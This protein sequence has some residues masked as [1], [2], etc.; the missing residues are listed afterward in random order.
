MSESDVVDVI[1]SYN[2]APSREFPEHNALT[3]IHHALYA[4]RIL[5]EV[6]A[7]ETDDD[8]IFQVIASRT[9]DDCIYDPREAFD[10]DSD[11]SFTLPT[12]E[13][14]HELITRLARTI[15]Y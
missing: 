3:E 14:V 2:P 8:L 4:Q 7:L 11:L 13:A 12:I 10:T 6:C 15:S 9:V 1:A 5:V